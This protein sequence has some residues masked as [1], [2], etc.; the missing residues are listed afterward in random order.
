MNN[1][2][3]DI[4]IKPILTEKMLKLQESQ[5]KYAFMV[6]RR[7]TKIDIK[8]AVQKKF[9]VTVKHV[10]T[11]NVK[12]KTKR[13]NT[14]RGITRGQRP[15]WKKAIITLREGDSIDFFESR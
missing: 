12:G 13:M 5:S 1:R 14:R 7:A 11:I 2:I 3:S 8:R 15:D 10:R 6:D 4:L 9:D